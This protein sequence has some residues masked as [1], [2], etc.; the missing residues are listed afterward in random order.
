[1]I[2]YHPYDVKI[3]KP[4]N[5]NRTNITRIEKKCA[6]KD[7][8]RFVTMGDSQGFYNETRDF[9]NEINHR[10]D[11]SVKSVYCNNSLTTFIE[12]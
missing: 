4:F 12:T 2:D 1:M 10:N 6:S 8:I 3:D 9:V 7:T 5:I 11:I